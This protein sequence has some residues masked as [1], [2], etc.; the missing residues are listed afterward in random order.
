MVR[1]LCGLNVVGNYD[2]NGVFRARVETEK[3][4][5]I[6]HVVIVDRGNIG[7]ERTGKY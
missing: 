6:K 4:N 3:G 1:I 7:G 2:G 5:S